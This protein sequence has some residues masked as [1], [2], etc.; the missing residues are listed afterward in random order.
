MTKKFNIE[1]DGKPIELELKKPTQAMADEVLE[2]LAGK[3]SESKAL[4][5][6]DNQDRTKALSLMKELGAKTREW[7]FS[8]LVSKNVI[9]NPDKLKN[10]ANDDLNQMRDWM[11]GICTGAPE[12]NQNFTEK[13]KG[14]SS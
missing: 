4:K 12:G 11:R 3:E 2:Y 14:S 6:P 1:Y 8:L 5:D 9:D 13:S 7:V 10:V